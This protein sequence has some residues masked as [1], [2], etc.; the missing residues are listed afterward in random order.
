MAYIRSGIKLID[1]FQAVHMIT[2]SYIFE[3]GENHNEGHTSL[4]GWS[5]KHHL[6][7]YKLEGCWERVH[8]KAVANL[9]L[10]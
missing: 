3:Q 4:E 9:T 6:F 8:Q 1:D 10:S 2:V 5:F 7:V